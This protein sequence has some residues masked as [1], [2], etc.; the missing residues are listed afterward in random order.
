MAIAV[1]QKGMFVFMKKVSF[2]SVRTALKG[3]GFLIALVLCVA[4]V[5]ISTYYA[6]NQAISQITGGLDL[7]TPITFTDFDL[8]A[9]QEQTGI[10]KDNSSGSIQPEN[11]PANN[12]ITVTVPKML[13]IPNAEV[14]NPY[15]NGELVKSQTLGVWKTHDGV[16]L[17]AEEGTMVLSMTNGTVSQVFEDP[18]WGVC[19]II[20]HGDGI[21]G[22][23]YG[24]SQDV[25]VKAG[26]DVEAG[27]IIGKVGNTADIESAL[28][29]HLHFAVKQNNA[30]VDPLQIIG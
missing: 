1:H 19:I 27:E 24:L 12:F 6:Y 15:S 5:G 23:Y 16:D 11:E 3:K 18:L 26:Q 4:A 29:S 30:W 21:E 7:N 22:H 9:N 13:P 17:A 8:P 28:P 14:I 2:S 25:S 20:N 10:P